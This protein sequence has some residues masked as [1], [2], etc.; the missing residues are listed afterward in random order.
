MSLD[1]PDDLVVPWRFRGPTHSGNGGWTAGALAGMV[2]GC[3]ANHA[4]RWPAVEVTLRSPPPL[5]TPL[6][7]VERDGACVATVGEMLVAEARLSDQELVDVPGVP[8]EL[9]VDAAAG[10]RGH[11]GHPFPECFTCGPARA[12][13][14]GLRI[15]PGRVPGDDRVAAPWTPAPS[16]REDYHHYADPETAG[17]VR[18]SLAVTWA[19]LDCVGGWA[20]DLEARPMVLGRITAQ[21]DTLPTVGEPHVVVGRQTGVEGRRTFTASTLYDA[22]GRPLARAAHVWFQVDPAAFDR[23]L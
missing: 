9:A 6:R 13:G 4:E 23:P 19:A 5:D 16:T 12:E 2:A 7:V 10:Y 3:P 1:E 21:V 22:S 11:R 8:A 20:G 14:D 18:A 15:F 17:S